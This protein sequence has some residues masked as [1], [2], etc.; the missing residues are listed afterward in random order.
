MSEGHYFIDPDEVQRQIGA[1]EEQLAALRAGKARLEKLPPNRSDYAAFG[2]DAARRA[3]SFHTD[4][5][6]DYTY[7]ALAIEGTIERMK[8]ARKAY[9]DLDAEGRAHIAGT[10][11]PTNETTVG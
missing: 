6:S 10:V 4:L 11:L 7:L 1:L 3:S 2:V 9:L 5:G 8:E